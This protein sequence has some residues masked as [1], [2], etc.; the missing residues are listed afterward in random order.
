M[1]S[2]QRNKFWK[3]LGEIERDPEKSSL[4]RKFFCDPV[5]NKQEV[6]TVSPIR[7]ILLHWIVPVLAGFGISYAGEDMIAVRCG[8]LGLLCAWLIVDSWIILWKQKHRTRWGMIATASLL[9][10]FALL[11]I[12]VYRGEHQDEKD[13][14]DIG[15][16]VNESVPLPDPNE[17]FS[18][19]FI[20]ANNSTVTL[21]RTQ[22]V[23][24]LNDLKYEAGGGADNDTV[25]MPKQDYP[26]PLQRGGDRETY[27]CAGDLI[28]RYFPVGPIK[29]ADIEIRINYAMPFDSEGVPELKTVRMLAQRDNG[30][31]RWYPINRTMPTGQCSGKSL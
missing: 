16:T 5:E 23:C 18:E 30:V 19:K 1:D 17:P 27:R 29:C 14:V 8:V 20:I 28:Q 13:K 24:K 12:S 7:Q 15:L 9:V 10:F 26:Y 2:N 3:Q 31:F 22:I 11:G 21:P 4:A 25:S 6:Q